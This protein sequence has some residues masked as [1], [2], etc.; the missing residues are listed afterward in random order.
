MCIW[1]YLQKSCLV[2]IFHQVGEMGSGWQV[3]FGV[4]LAYHF[5]KPFTSNHGEWPHIRDQH[6]KY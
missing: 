6:V 1:T 3:V 4:E 5:F 2:F